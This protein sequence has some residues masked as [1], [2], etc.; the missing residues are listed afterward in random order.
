MKKAIIISTVFV[1]LVVACVG[2]VCYRNS[3]YRKAFI[4]TMWVI[5]SNDKCG[6]MFEQDGTCSYW[7]II[8]EGD[9]TG[10]SIPYGIERYEIKGNVLT[11]YDFNLRVEGTDEVIKDVDFKIRLKGDSV[12]LKCEYYDESLDMTRV[13]AKTVQEYAKTHLGLSVPYQ[14]EFAE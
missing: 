10:T 1:L 4:D 5:D 11:M 9:G 12:S 2:F 8:D 3:W 14:G 6:F 7:K 13:D